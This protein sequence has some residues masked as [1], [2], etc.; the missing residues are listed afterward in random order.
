L[1]L[2]LLPRLLIPQVVL[3]IMGGMVIGPHVLGLG[4][5]GGVQILADVGLGF[6]FLL[7]GYEVDL[8]LLGQDA[9]RRAVAAWFAS[10]SPSVRW[11]C[12]PPRGWFARSCR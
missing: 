1:V 5:P 12:S 7:A 4:T 6:V 3:L 8:R 2:G 10:L 9:G 11:H